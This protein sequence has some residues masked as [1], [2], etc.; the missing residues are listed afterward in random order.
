[1]KDNIRVFVVAL[2]LFLS[3]AT[4]RTVV[5]QAPPAAGTASASN[6]AMRVRIGTPLVA[7]GPAPNIADNWFTEVGLPDGR[8]RGFTANAATLATDGKHPYEMSGPAVTVLKPGPA[9]SPSA[10]GE[11]IQH[12]ELED[13]TLYGWVHSETACHY[14]NNGQTHASMTIATSA[15]YGLTWKIEGRI[16]A[17]NDPPVVGRETGDSCPSVIR[18]KDGYDYAYCLH[19]GGHP[20]GGG[21]KFI[22]RAPASDP[23][24]GKWKRYFDGNW[25]EPGIGGSATPADALGVAYWTTTGETIALNPVKG[26][27]GLAASKDRLHFTPAFSQPLMLAEPS[28]WSRKNGLELHAYFVAIDAHTGLNQLGDHWLLSY[29]YLNPGDGFNKRYLVFQP[30]DIYWS[31]TPDEPQVG[32]MLTHWYDAAQHDHWVTTAPVP[33]NYTAY[34]MIAPLGYI[35]TAPDPKEASIELEE[36]ASQSSEHVDHILIQKGLCETQGYQRLRGAGFIFSSVQP[37]THPLYLCY[38]KTEKS[39]FA[40]NVEDC[41]KMG[42]KEALLG[43]TLS[44]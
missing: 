13:K 30:V 41:N 10:C 1:M 24:P 4:A 3:L 26:G 36:C 35:M 33:G 34:K 7:R 2:T 39:H 42:S 18:D 28:D 40:A 31:R 32:E 38:S 5:A 9:G 16:I 37:D 20:W 19:N 8:F 14:S 12:V 6:G 29:L 25:S 43:Y 27:I 44:K 11:W 21:Y 17:S 22:A 23:D 15:D